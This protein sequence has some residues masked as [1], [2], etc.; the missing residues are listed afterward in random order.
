M[1]TVS[2][3]PEYQESIKTAYAQEPFY[4]STEEGLGLMQEAKDVI[5][6]FEDQM[7]G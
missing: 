5:W 1:K 4:A 6:S 7:A 3:K 2:E